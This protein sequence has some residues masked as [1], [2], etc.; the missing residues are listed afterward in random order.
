MKK[1]RIFR[2]VI[3]MLVVGFMVFSSLGGSGV[4]ATNAAKA[5]EDPVFKETSFR[6]ILVGGT[7]DFD[8][9][10][11][12]P[13]STYHWESSNKKVATVNN[14]GVVKAREAGSTTI[15][16]K[17]ISGKSIK[18]LEAK[19]VVQKPSRKPAEKVVINNKIQSMVVGETYDLNY[20]FTPKDAS[21]SV[22]WT[23]SDTTI[24]RV[25]EKGVVTA[26]KSG[27][28]TIKATTVN[29][30]R[31]DK[32]EIKVSTEVE[33]AS[34]KE[35]ENALKSS[36]ASTILI[37]SKKDI[38]LII[39]KGNYSEKELVVDAPKASIHNY[40]IF[41]KV[42]IRALKDH[43]WHEFA[44]GNEINVFD[45]AKITVEKNADCEIIVDK[46]KDKLPKPKIKLDLTLNGNAKIEALS[47]CDIKFN[48]TTKDLPKLSVKS[49]DVKINTKIA[50]QMDATHKAVLHL[51]TEA[52]SKSK[53][54][55]NDMKSIP[56]VE[57]RFKVYVEVNGKIYI[58]G[59]DSIAT[60]TVKPT[61]VPTPT[62][63]SA[64]PPVDTEVDDK[65]FTAD[66]RIVAKYGTPKIDGEIDEVWNNAIEIQPP[67]I[68]SPAVQATATFKVLWD[69]YALYFLAQVKDPNM[70]VAPWNAY[71]QDS[72]EIFLDENNDKTPSYGAD[73]LHF[74]VNYNNVQSI[75]NGDGER[76]YTATKI[77]DN[78]YLVEGRI[79]LLNTAKN[80]TIYGIEL[81]VNDCIGTSR[82]GT[83]T[84]FDKTDSAWNNTSLFGE[85]ILTG[86]K[87]G[88]VP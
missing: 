51:E 31:T 14:E 41:K 75:D 12:P 59:K 57:G 34:Q 69:D 2:Q 88:D 17:I 50:I 47:P 37:N 71:E 9:A 49:A 83:I 54:S 19:V 4:Q 5:C 16:C 74:R 11:K 53:I 15:T 18:T 82:A 43:N 24:A 80:N 58:V 26:L 10:N 8:I 42:T 55:V 77:G 6:T 68:N 39:P 27:K 73:D 33:V 86:K 7:Y 22:N 45:S 40:G 67:N 29:K 13:K 78:E 76:F 23:S 25:D 35:L 70:S 65:G 30:S 66:G 44:K 48:G 3:A 28:V 60:P 79:E 61:A 64:I 87:D 38:K 72:V 56:K 52:A 46:N 36:K 62:A 32:V 84:V 20:S 85:I 81:Q 21:D 63:T 1:S